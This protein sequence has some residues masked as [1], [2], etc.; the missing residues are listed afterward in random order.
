MAENPKR[1]YF[2]TYEEYA[3]YVIKNH[4]DHPFIRDVIEKRNFQ[5]GQSS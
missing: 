4:S 1:Q 2:R 5:S 3:N